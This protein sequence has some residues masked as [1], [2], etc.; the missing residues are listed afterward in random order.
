MYL[1]LNTSIGM[2]SRI[3]RT[4]RTNTMFC[5]ENRNP[6]ERVTSTFQDLPAFEDIINIYLLFLQR[7][8][9]I[10][11]SYTVRKVVTLLNF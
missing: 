7:T 2:H 3:V 4:P 6:R 10:S 1:S 9:V 8:D 5:I 11:N